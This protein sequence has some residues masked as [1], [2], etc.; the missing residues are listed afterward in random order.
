LLRLVSAALLLALLAA[1]FYVMW[2]DFA[3]ATQGMDANRR[4]YG[5]L[6]RVREIDG[7][8]V[9]TPEAY[10]LMPLTSMG[11]TP[12]NVVQVDDSFASS[13]HA[14]VALRNGRWWLEDRRSTNGTLLNGV[15]ITQP[16]II[17]EGDVISIG[18]THYRL[19][20]ED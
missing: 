3:A 13:D 2:R 5:R 4:I 6:V 8:Y 14:V 7:K 1:F 16:V 19:D 18:Q 9:E 17:T 20:L 15:S 10:P 11:R 12:T